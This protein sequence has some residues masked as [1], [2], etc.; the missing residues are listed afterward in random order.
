MLVI[1]TSLLVA[2]V[3][4]VEVTIIEEQVIEVSLTQELV[5]IVS[6]LLAMALEI[7]S[8]IEV[9]TAVAVIFALDIREE[10]APEGKAVAVTLELTLERIEETCP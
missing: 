1:E 9:G 8:A 4:A 7:A 5:V 2:L 6:F 3:E 10:M